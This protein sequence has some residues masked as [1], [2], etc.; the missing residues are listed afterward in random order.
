MTSSDRWAGGGPIIS[1]SLA[2]RFSVGKPRKEADNFEIQAVA[3]G[4]VPHPPVAI[5]KTN[6]HHEGDPRLWR[7]Y[8]K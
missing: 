1:E 4:E 2:R 7:K 5:V 8:G 6:G 3:P